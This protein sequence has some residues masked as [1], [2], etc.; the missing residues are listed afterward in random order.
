MLPVRSFMRRSVAP[1][2]AIASAANA[3][4]PG[5]KAPTPLGYLD[6]ASDQRWIYFQQTKVVADPKKGIYTASFTPYL[7]RVDGTQFSISGFML[8]VEATT[9]TRHFILTRRNSSCPFCPQNEPTEA[10]EVFTQNSVA[11][12]K[13]AIIVEGRLQLVARS[14]DGLFYRL[15]GAKVL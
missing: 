5:G 13:D 2:L 9:S 10:I 12:S 4:T 6:H 3:F 14:A 15:E 7:D 11:V 1:L 8:S